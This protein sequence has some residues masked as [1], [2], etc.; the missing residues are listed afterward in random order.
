MT[1]PGQLRD[2]T[3]GGENGV[4]RCSTKR[5]KKLFFAIFY[6][7]RLVTRHGM[8][9]T[10]TCES[11]HPP[12]ADRGPAG[13]GPKLFRT[14]GFRSRALTD[15]ELREETPHPEDGI[16]KQNAQQG[17]QLKGFLKRHLD[18]PHPARDIFAD[19]FTRIHRHPPRHD[20]YQYVAK[21]RQLLAPLS[22][23]PTK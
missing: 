7:P 17:A 12:E 9:F 8:T 20:T 4:A 5:S 1:F 19:I 23:L 22:Y 13:Q 10:R 18:T 14:E 6:I 16:Q 3:T 21:L 11:R 2:V 15:N